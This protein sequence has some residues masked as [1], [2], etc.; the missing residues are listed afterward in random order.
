MLKNINKTFLIIYIGQASS[1]LT[2]SILQMSIV[3]Y[4]ISETNS[5]YLNLY[6]LYL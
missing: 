4:P 1:Q 6:Y 2:S 5:K 3:W